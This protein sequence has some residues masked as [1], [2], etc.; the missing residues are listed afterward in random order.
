MHINHN[1]LQ[2][3]KPIHY[4][5][6]PSTVLN[7]RQ[8]AREM[9]ERERERKWTL[10]QWTMKKNYK[11]KFFSGYRWSKCVELTLFFC[12]ESNQIT[13]KRDMQNANSSSIFHASHL[14]TVWE[15]QCGCTIRYGWSKFVPIRWH[16]NACSGYC[17]FSIYVFDCNFFCGL[18]R[19]YWPV[20]FFLLI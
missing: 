12:I 19:W 20:F 7:D 14:H 1:S 15:Q 3:H 9:Q 2:T 13:S 6:H 17:I 16:C 8:N 5:Q 4:H 11:R 18:F 10:T